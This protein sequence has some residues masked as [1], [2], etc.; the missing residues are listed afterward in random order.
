[1][2]PTEDPTGPDGPF[3]ADRS[4]GRAAVL[5][6]LA[7]VAATYGILAD[8]AYRAVP[9]L[10]RQTWRAQDAV[11][12]ASL[13]VLVRAARRAR[14]GSLP[15]HLVATGLS[16]WLAYCYA[17]L[18]LGSP[19]TPAFLLYV[20]ILGTAGFG[21]LDGLLRVDVERVAP[22]FARAP[23][24]LAAAFLAASGAGIAL[25]WLSD[26]V[27]GLLGGVPANLHLAGLA[28]PTW[29]LDLA[30]VIPWAFGAAA[31]LRRRHPAGPTVAAVLLVML[32]VL[33]VAMLV[34][35]PFA[36]AAGLGA[37]PAAAPQLAAFT[38]VFAALGSV[39]LGL[40]VLGRRRA[41]PVGAWRRAGWWASR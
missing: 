17:H 7:A 32:L 9:E 37:D 2:T 18:A 27:R 10:L 28:N 16:T 5:A 29:V 3:W 8:D 21:T 20:A 35:T 26:I 11:T 33:S 34:T 12:L 38:V 15:A 39:E 22:A 1:M 40:L 24:G 6:A 23:A 30:W 14:T 13:P 19:V 4:V 36:L 31:L 25:L 41:A